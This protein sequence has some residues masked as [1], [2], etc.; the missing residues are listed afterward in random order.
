VE[1][2]KVMSTDEQFARRLRFEADDVPVIPVDARRILQAGR[3]RRQLRPLIGAA[4]GALGIMVA[5][6]G[7][8]ALQPS[9]A[10]IG[11]AGEGASATQPADA[12][13]ADPVTADPA[14][15]ASRADAALQERRAEAAALSAELG[16][17]DQASP[18]TEVTISVINGQTVIQY[19]DLSTLRMVT[20]ECTPANGSEARTP[21]G[22]SPRAVL[23]LPQKVAFTSTYEACVAQF[24]QQAGTTVVATKP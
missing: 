4:T 6:A 8:A 9:P 3:R 24:P 2:E 14:A 23:P 13:T 10:A 22:T 16:F 21:I 18:T 11:P 19:R 12:V 15:Q 5:V 1:K 7:F 20:I 17:K